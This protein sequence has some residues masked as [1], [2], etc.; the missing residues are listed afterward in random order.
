MC[1]FLYPKANTE[2]EITKQHIATIKKLTEFVFGFSAGLIS[3][4]FGLLLTVLV[5]FSQYFCIKT[6]CTN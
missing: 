6:A 4:T 2:P 3:G 1:F 5:K